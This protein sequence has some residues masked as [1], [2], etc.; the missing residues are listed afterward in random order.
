MSSKESLPLFVFPRID[1]FRLKKEKMREKKNHSMTFARMST[2]RNNKT[3]VK[4]Y[5]V[6]KIHPAMLQSQNY[7]VP[8]L[9]AEEMMADLLLNIY[10]IAVQYRKY[11]KGSGVYICK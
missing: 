2:R 8:S 5:D 4:I 6:H 1:H 11:G 7:W 9:Q 10:Y 3:F